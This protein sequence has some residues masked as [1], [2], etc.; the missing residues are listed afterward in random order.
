[1]FEQIIVPLDGSNVAE[2]TL[3]YVTE[4]ASRFGSRI[5]LM[6]VSDPITENEAHT[7]IREVAS[8]MRLQL[9]DWQARDEA[10]VSSELR[11]GNP[12]L[13]IINYAN[14]IAC[15]LIA[16]ASRGASG[17]GPWSLGNVAGKVLRSSNIPV[18]LVRKAADVE[19]VSQKRLIKK[20]LVP[21][22]GSRLGET[23]IPLIVSL[24]RMLEAEIVLFQVIEPSRYLLASHDFSGLSML[25]L[26]EYEKSVRASALRYLNT[27]KEL[28][29][30][31]VPDVSVVTVEGMVADGIIDY[32]RANSADLIAMATHGRS[33][34]GRWVFG[35]VTDKV[36]HAGD[37][38][39][40]VVR[41][42]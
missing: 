32:A 1:M 8:R 16:I 7:Y 24:A 36:L 5:T 37:T 4:I 29:Q 15:N 20:I 14:E 6:R 13:Q 12:A 33:G 41:P 26:D 30:K 25:T 39:V 11:T 21:L 31:T 34:I 40:L 42:G 27:T 28:V 23:A 9:K 2:I 10:E 18:L 38:P 22:D 35:S 17:E 19:A 3:P